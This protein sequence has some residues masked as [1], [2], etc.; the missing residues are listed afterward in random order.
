MGANNKRL[1]EFFLPD[2]RLQYV[3]L[4]TKIKTILPFSFT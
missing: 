2:D 4:N 1:M 3:K